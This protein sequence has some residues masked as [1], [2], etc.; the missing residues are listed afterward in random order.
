MGKVSLRADVRYMVSNNV[1]MR[2]VVVSVDPHKV[3]GH[4]C[5]LKAT[6]RKSSKGCIVGFQPLHYRL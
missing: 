5:R 6:K 2:G 3:V 4:E 1:V